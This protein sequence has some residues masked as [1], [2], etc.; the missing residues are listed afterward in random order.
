MTASVGEVTKFSSGDAGASSSKSRRSR[1][2][3]TTELPYSIRRYESNGDRHQTFLVDGKDCQSDRKKDV[4]KYLERW[5]REWV[6]MQAKH[7][8][9]S[10]T[11][12]GLCIT[13][14]DCEPV[15]RS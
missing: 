3:Y 8:N 12:L 15:E 2:T 5:D 7:P 11:R 6:E 13:D 4:E 14:T 9:N 10:K 1:D